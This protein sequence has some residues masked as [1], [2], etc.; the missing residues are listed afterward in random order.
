[1]QPRSHIRRFVLLMTCGMLTAG[2]MCVTTGCARAWRP[3]PVEF[4][5][6]QADAV[7]NLADYLPKTATDRVY[8]RRNLGEPDEP[9]RPYPRRSAPGAASEGLLAGRCGAKAPPASSDAAASSGSVARFLGDSDDART[10]RGELWPMDAGKTSAACFLEFDPPLVDLPERISADLPFAQRCRLRCYDRDAKLWREGTAT[11]RVFFE[12]L[13]SVTTS[14]QTY[15]DCARLRIDTHIRL[16][17]GPRVNV[18]TYSWLAPGFGEVRRVEEIS[19]LALL[20]LFDE[21]YEYELIEAVREAALTSATRP[22]GPTTRPQ[23]PKPPSVQP[24][25]APYQPA[26]WSRCAIFLDRSLPHP[27]LGGLVA[28]LASV[29]ADNQVAATRGASTPSA[30]STPP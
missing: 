19:G 8:L 7:L 17:W 22:A 23:R 4:V 20:I 26:A 3:S 28:E 5:A 6:P 21:V 16:R 24:D 30:R 2:S 11:R 12:S 15:A 9:P 13:E 27:R 18:T 10:R 1:M 29:A 25:F 14:S